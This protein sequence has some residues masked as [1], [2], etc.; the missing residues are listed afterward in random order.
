MPDAIIIGAGPNGLVGANVLADAGWTVTVLEAQPQPGGAVRTAEVTA[1]GFRN[2]L[3]SAF[4]P[5]TF[6]SPVIRRFHLEDWGLQW[7]H[8]PAVV[9]HPPPGGPAAV[10]SRDL[11]TT[12]A[13]LDRFAPGDGDAWQDLYDL[14][15]RAQPAFVE[16][17]LDPFPPVKAA[18]KLL[19]KLRIARSV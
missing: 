9:A 8:A 13:S 14:F 6:A 15:H 1:P 4:Y 7:R 5:L 11:D 3:F 17:L 12:C 16:L 2:D 19:A 10:L 18:A